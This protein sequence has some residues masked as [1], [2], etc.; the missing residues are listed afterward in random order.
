MGAL[1]APTQRKEK[2]FRR[3]K[4]AHG[5]MGSIDRLMR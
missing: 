3:I 2:L 1:D 4:R 5:G